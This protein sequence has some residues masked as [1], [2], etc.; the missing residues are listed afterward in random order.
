MRTIQKKAY[1]KINLHL[2]VLSRYSDGYHEVNTV[3]HSLSLCDDIE[4][5]IKK[6]DVDKITI[7]CDNSNIPTDNKNIVWRAA[8]LFLSTVDINY[9]LDIIINITKRIPVEAGLGGGSADA[10]ATLCAL[11]ELCGEPLDRMS[12]LG[13]GASLGADV[14]FCMVGGCA[15]ADGK[16]DRLTELI[17]LPMC[18]IVVARGGEGVSTPWAYK[19]IDQKYGGFSDGSY[20]ARDIKPILNAIESTDL[21]YIANNFYNVFEEAILPERHVAAELK[22]ILLEN[23]AIGALMSG[24]GTA[25]FGI[26]TEEARAVDVV[27]KISDLGYFAS[28]AMPSS[29]YF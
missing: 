29:K 16:G 22:G 9:P 2:D 12:L 21:H 1:A 27:K 28:V 20:I 3:M 17:T 19:T 14:P 10:A 24:S 8:E 18:Y 25:V 23:G 15:Y 7:I 5:S 4:I 26:F 11:N 13:L 6:S